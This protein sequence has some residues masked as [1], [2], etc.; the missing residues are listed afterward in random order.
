MLGRGKEG[1]SGESLTK[2]LHSEPQPD[3]PELK[4][5]P[6]LHPNA[7]KVSP[8]RSYEQSNRKPTVSLPLSIKVADGPLF[9]SC[10][11]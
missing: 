6:D 5:L 8:R 3:R 7:S 10:S 11:P 4:M 1:S 2:L 9:C